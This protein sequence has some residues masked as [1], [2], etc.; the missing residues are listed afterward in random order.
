MCKK[1]PRTHMLTLSQLCRAYAFSQEWRMQAG[2]HAKSLSSMAHQSAYS[3]MH[4]CIQSADVCHHD[5]GWGWL[6]SNRAQWPNAHT[7]PFLRTSRHSCHAVGCVSLILRLPGTSVLKLH[8]VAE[9]P[10]PVPSS[11]SR[12]L[13]EL[14]GNMGAVPFCSVLFWII[15][16]AT[17]W[18]TVWEKLFSDWVLCPGVAFQEPMLPARIPLC[19]TW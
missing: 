17:A 10:L 15:S 8:G 12:D 9:T 18:Q 1:L 13:N 2:A 11:V 6:N 7:Q 14:P 16:N 4:R 3:A 19:A 5:A